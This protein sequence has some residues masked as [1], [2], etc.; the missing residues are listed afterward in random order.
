MI[1]IIAIR[2]YNSK[3]YISLAAHWFREISASMSR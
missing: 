3:H 1:A 2:Y